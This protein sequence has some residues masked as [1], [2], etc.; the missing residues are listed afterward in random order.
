MKKNLKKFIVENKM[1]IIIV[2]ILLLL[3]SITVYFSFAF[4]TDESNYTLIDGS[5]GYFENPDLSINFL[6]E[7]RN[8]DGEGIGTYTSYWVAPSYNYTFN[9]STSSCT[10]GA[11]YTKNDADVFSISTTGKTKCYF[12]YDAVD[13]DSDSDIKIIVLREAE[14]SIEDTD[15]DGYI[16][17]YNYTVEGL[18]NLGLGF[19]LSKSYCST[20]EAS[21]Y[22]DED[23]AEIIVS[24]N[25]ATTCYAYFDEANY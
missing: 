10:N 9:S 22:F 24:S 14:T 8:S 1:T 2:V 17:S 11:S 18:Y 13:L 4:Y 5:I 19:N 16:T 15:G 23:A 3:I 21:V 20:D 7:D 12:Y 25:E 6:V